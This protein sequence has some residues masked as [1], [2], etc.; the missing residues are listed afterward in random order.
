MKFDRII[1]YYDNGQKSLTKIIASVFNALFSDVE[2]RKVT[3]VDY[4]LFQVADLICTL[5]LIK[6]KVN[7][8]AMSTSEIEF[9]ESP[10]AFKK[11]IYKNIAKK[12]LDQ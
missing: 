7:N 5:E 11:N 9:F 6:D 2:F 1:V 12:K 3:P 4:K 10:R 8:N